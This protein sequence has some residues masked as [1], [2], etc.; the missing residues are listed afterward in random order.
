ML[1]VQ[2]TGRKRVAVATLADA[3]KAV[4]DY[5]LG[6]SGSRWYTMGGPDIGNV[7]DEHGLNIARVSYNGRV[8]EPGPLYDD[9][10]EIKI[11]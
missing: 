7:Y 6:K 8:W 4:S 5:T 3:S 2:I 1:T 10:R 11:G 9:K